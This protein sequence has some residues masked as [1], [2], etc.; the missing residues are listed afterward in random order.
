MSQGCHEQCGTQHSPQQITESHD[1]PQITSLCQ[2]NKRCSGRASCVVG[3]R[4]SRVPNRWIAIGHAKAPG[5]PGSTVKHT[6][7]VR[8]NLP[9]DGIQERAS[10]KHHVTLFKLKRRK[11]AVVTGRIRRTTHPWHRNCAVVAGWHI[12][13][14]TVA[15]TNV[16]E[17]TV[18]PTDATGDGTR[19]GVDHCT[20]TR[21]ELH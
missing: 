9:T 3:T 15:G 1:D 21:Q 17:I 14:E 11:F 6:G 19:F 10:R 13:S 8:S 2:R 12:S 5:L 20:R 4:Q 16:L 18:R 7:V